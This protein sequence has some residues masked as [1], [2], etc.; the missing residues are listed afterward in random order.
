MKEQ[1]QRTKCFS[2]ETGESA[3]YGE[4]M[5]RKGLLC[6]SDRYFFGS[7]AAYAGAAT[8]NVLTGAVPMEVV[9]FAWLGALTLPLV[10]PPIGRLIGLR[11]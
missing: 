5:R 9:S 10:A 6:P 4:G 8:V 1:R 7:M 11:R 3:S 2:M